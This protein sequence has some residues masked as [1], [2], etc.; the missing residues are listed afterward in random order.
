METPKIRLGSSFP[1]YEIKFSEYRKQF[2]EKIIEKVTFLKTSHAIGT[3][4]LT[5]LVM[6]ASIAFGFTSTAASAI[7]FITFAFELNKSSL[8]I[9]TENL[10][11]FTL[12]LKE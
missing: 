12:P 5:G 2:K 7:V 4:E 6:M 11:E 8:V 10:Q 1:A 3:Q 9:P